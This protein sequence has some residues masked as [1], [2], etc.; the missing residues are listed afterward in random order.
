MTLQ[1]RFSQALESRGEKLIKTTFRYRVYSR[2]K[3]GFY[4]LGRAGALRVGRTIANSFPCSEQ[5]REQLLNPYGS[6]LDQIVSA[7]KSYGDY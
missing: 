6:D 4:Y 3:G 2:A 5:F 7:I 1:D